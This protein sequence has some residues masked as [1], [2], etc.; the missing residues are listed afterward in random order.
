MVEERF[1][2]E[3]RTLAQLSHPHIVRIYDVGQAGGRHFIAMELVQGPGLARRLEREP[4]DL[5]ET[6]RL[7]QQICSA[8]EFIHE[9]GIIHRDIKPE[10]ILLDAEGNARLSDFGLVKLREETGSVLLSGAHSLLGTPAYMSPEQ[11]RGQAV[12]ARADLFSLGAV[13]YRMCTG[14]LPFPGENASSVL[15]ALAAH[16]PEPPHTLRPGV[17]PLLS[18]LILRLLAKDPANRPASAAEVRLELER[19]ANGDHREPSPATRSWRDRR[20]LIGAVLACLLLIPLGAWFADVILR[21]EGADG[22]LQVEVH[23]PNLLVAVRDARKVPLRQKS[24]QREFQLNASRGEVLVYETDGEQLLLTLPFELHKGK[25]TTVQV[26]PQRVAAARDKAS[27]DMAAALALLPWKPLFNGK[28]LTGWKYPP[29]LPGEWKVKDGNL[30]GEGG[31]RGWLFYDRDGIG[32]FQLHCEYRSSLHCDSGIFFWTPFQF[33]KFAD[34]ALNPVTWHEMNIDDNGRLNF[35]GSLDGQGLQAP[36]R[37]A[38]GTAHEWT[39]VDI[40]A[41]GSRV[42]VRVNGKE[43]ATQVF[44]KAG[45]GYLALQTPLGEDATIEIRKLEIRLPNKQKAGK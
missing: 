35:T 24:A 20:A 44:P 32:S 5:A 37:E 39:T 13:L 21:I 15:M 23:D 41:A 18:G 33:K 16:Q 40:L 43:T 4:A 8:L 19:L 29:E 36:V 26:D 45:S 28:D 11:A 27:A 22:T 7:G 6:L 34:G 30:V 2:R 31:Q 14:R 25:T 12:D 38:T 9:Q 3:A 1:L 10:N 17:P 42:S